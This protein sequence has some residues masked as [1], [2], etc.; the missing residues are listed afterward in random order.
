MTPVLRA[1]LLK[2]SLR[3]RTLAAEMRDQVVIVPSDVCKAITE[4]C[5]I[6]DVII[7]SDTDPDAHINKAARKIRKGVRARPPQTE[8]P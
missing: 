5:G 4:L 3:V 8:K 6:I 7:L 2:A 1:N